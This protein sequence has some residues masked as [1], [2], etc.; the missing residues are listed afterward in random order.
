VLGNAVA[1]WVSRIQSY[2][3]IRWLPTD[4]KTW[5]GIGLVAIF[6][7]SA[8]KT[9]EPLHANRSGFRTAGLWIA[10][11]AQDNDVVVDPYSWSHYYAGRVFLEGKPVSATN[12]HA[13]ICYVVLEKSGNK[14][15]RLTIVPIAEKLAET[16]QLAL[17]LRT[18]RKN[19]V[20]DICVYACPLA[21]KG[22]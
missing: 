20:C 6:V 14:H 17:E 13:P 9:L 5:A 21:K 2:R 12:D 1:K 16:G 4:G 19:D 15:D 22:K 18:K 11:H 7:G 3:L 10:D 8:P